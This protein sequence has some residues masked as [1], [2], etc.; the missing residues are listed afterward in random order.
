M[1]LPS[2]S[3]NT[4]GLV[5]M[6]DQGDRMTFNLKHYSLYNSTETINYIEEVN[7]YV[8]SL[9]ALPDTMV[10]PSSLYQGLGFYISAV[11]Y[12]T[13]GSQINLDG[14]GF[15]WALV[16]DWQIAVPL[17]NWSLL[18]SVVDN[19]DTSQVI[20]NTTVWGFE[21]FVNYTT[22]YNDYQRIYYKLDG[23]LAFRRFNL[24]G[25]AG[26]SL[27]WDLIRLD[28]PTPGG[29]LTLDPTLILVGGGV[30]VAIVVVGLLVKRRR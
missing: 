1:V 17:E 28:P 13:N 14:G 6:V 21:T 7:A 16:F 10:F 2:S 15:N 8:Q 24:T 26:Y 22:F 12:W 20:E 18:S 23:S 25:L 11:F 30:I 3:V 4:S 5:W 29:P 19:D 27:V 9:G